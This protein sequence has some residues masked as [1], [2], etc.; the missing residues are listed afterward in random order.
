[1]PVAVAAGNHHAVGAAVVGDRPVGAGSGDAA[2]AR[3]GS[4]RA[5]VDGDWTDA[6][7]YDRARLGVGAVVEGPAIIT[8]LDTTSWLLPGQRGEVHVTGSII[9]TDDRV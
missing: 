3:T 4:L 1:V 6:A 5:Y 9:V 8:Q 7:I 2:A